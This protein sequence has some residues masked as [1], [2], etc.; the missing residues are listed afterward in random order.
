MQRN[1][2]YTLSTSQILCQGEPILSVRIKDKDG[3]PAPD[4]VTWEKSRHLATPTL[5]GFPAKWH[6]RNERRN[7]SDDGSIT[8][9]G[10]SSDWLKQV[11][12]ASRPIRSTNQIWVVIPHFYACFPVVIS[13][14][15]QWRRLVSTVFQ[16]KDNHTEWI[17][18]ES[19]NIR[20]HCVF[21]S[22][23]KLHREFVLVIWK[24]LKV[25]RRALCSWE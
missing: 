1:N 18:Y 7:F 4:N 10:S 20:M 9:S 24:Q 14:G 17:P 22:H 15:N 12:N 8:R 25:K 23:W 3:T 19:K 6:L 5:H 13:R 16:A 11:S 2:S 21:S